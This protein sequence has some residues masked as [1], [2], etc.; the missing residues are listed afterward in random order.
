MGTRKRNI[1]AGL[2][3]VILLITADQVTKEIARTF[4]SGTAG[5][6]LIP[7]VFKLSFVKNT[8][9]AF[10]MFRNRQILFIVIAVLIAIL[11]V[12]VYLSL[13]DQKKYHLLRS[14]CILITAGAIGNMI[15]RLING[16]VTDFLEIILF[17]FPV[18]NLADSFVC[19]GVFLVVISLFTL[20][21]NDDFSFLRLSQ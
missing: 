21:R 8:G 1:I 19:I 20:Y 7:G 15:D 2:V 6:V 5:Y 16:F 12:Y 3:A 18:F 4:L 17:R 13:P 11:A 9:A 10:G 14:E